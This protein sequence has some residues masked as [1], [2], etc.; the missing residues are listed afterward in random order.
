M[1]VGSRGMTRGD[2]TYLFT[3]YLEETVSTVQAKMKKA[4]RVLSLPVLFWTV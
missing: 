1:L 3:F 2:S 4:G